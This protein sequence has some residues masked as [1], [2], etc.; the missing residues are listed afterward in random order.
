LTQDGKVFCWGDNQCRQCDVP[1]DLENVIAVKCGWTHSVALKAN[2][3]VAC[4]GSNSDDECS[5]PRGLENI[6]AVSGGAY[7]SAA[8]TDDGKVVCWGRAPDK[9]PDDIYAMTGLILM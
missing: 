1:L 3:K 5:V 4:W 6:N 8:V 9:I 7:F 2:G